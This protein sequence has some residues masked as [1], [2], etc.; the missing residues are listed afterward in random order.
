MKE[1]GKIDDILDD[2]WKDWLDNGWV[3]VS[4]R[5]IGRILD[6]NEERLVEF[7]IDI[8]RL[9]EFGRIH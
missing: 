5:E 2:F 6:R 3:L 7:W 4:F 1:F 8:D 9:E